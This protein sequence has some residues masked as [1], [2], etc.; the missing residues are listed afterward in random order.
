[1]NND[2][3]LKFENYVVNNL[4][5][6]IENTSQYNI[7]QKTEK[8]NVYLNDIKASVSDDEKT[9]TLHFSVK[10]ETDLKDKNN[11][12]ISFR[13]LKFDFN[14]F[15]SVKGKIN[16]K[17]LSDI[18]KNLGINIAVTH[19]KDV[20]KSIT[21]VDYQNPIFISDIEFPNDKIKPEN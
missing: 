2:L 4:Q 3:T 11:K 7:P 19:I 17:S 13:H 12:A 18:L 6:S 14:I 15:F 10:I 21:S 9:V 1:M 16:K 8:V 20:V 5:Y